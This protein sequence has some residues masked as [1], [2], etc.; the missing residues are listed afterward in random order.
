MNLFFTPYSLLVAL[1][2]RLTGVPTV[3]ALGLFGVVNIGLLIVAMVWLARRLSPHPAMPALTLFALVM[4]WG[5]RPWSWSGFLHLDVI[6]YVAS[7]PSTFAAALLFFGLRVAF[8]AVEGGWRSVTALV[9]L[10]GVS[11][12]V[13]PLTAVSL[14]AGVAAIFL[15]LTKWE[16]DRALKML[17]LLTL[18]L[19]SASLLALSWPYFSI[20]SIALGGREFHAIAI[21]LYT[22]VIQRTWPALLAIPLLATR[23]RHDR[24]D[25]LVLFVGILA[26]VYIFG[27]VSERFALGRVISH[28][29]IGLQLIAAEFTA[30]RLAGLRSTGWRL[31]APVVFMLLF[32]LTAVVLH[33]KALA[34]ARPGP[35]APYPTA[36]IE[37]FVGKNDVVL[38]D[39][40]TSWMVPAFT[41]RVIA[42]K[43][44]LYGV[45]QNARRGAL[46][47]FFNPATTSEERTSILKQYSVDWILV[48]RKKTPPAL[49][50]EIQGMGGLTTSTDRYALIRVTT[51]GRDDAVI[52]PVIEVSTT[53]YLPTVR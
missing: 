41:G 50:H 30:A 40:D 8:D 51:E 1:V 17:L 2:A 36:F 20:L 3:E 23:L 33:P 34:L 13:H 12:V 43:H 9:C 11:I 16:C 29:C 48:D 53:N 49:L 45:D 6:F 10:L 47:L 7:Y 15:S 39:L 24:R 32:S 4:L 35:V 38:A 14:L 26:V 18:V 46:A 42:A 21:P 37:P 22:N 19:G 31:A 52:S 27:Y 44:P 5:D 28:A 25:P